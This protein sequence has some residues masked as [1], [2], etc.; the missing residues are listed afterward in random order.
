VTGIAIYIGIVGSF[1]VAL[2]I[3]S[4]PA[5]LS[6][7]S[8]FVGSI[9]GVSF[10]GLGA[11]YLVIGI[12]YLVMVYGLLKGMKWAWT[13]TIILTVIVIAMYITAEITG[14]ISNNSTIGSMDWISNNSII[15]KIIQFVFG[16]IPTVGI[17]YYLYRPHVRSFFGKT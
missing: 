2:F 6:D 1:F 10:A 12:V 14:S 8:A 15:V 17:I 4:I 5:D 11:V 3:S 7:W 9:F 16:L 13:I